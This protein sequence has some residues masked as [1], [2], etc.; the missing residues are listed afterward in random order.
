MYL[1]LMPTDNLPALEIEQADKLYHL[2]AYVFLSLTWFSYFI[3]FKNKQ[4]NL[5]FNIIAAALI[6]FGIVVEVLQSTLTDYRTFDWWDILSNSAGTL[7]V[8]F[9][10]KLN[11]TKLVKLRHQL[12]V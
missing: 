9:I 1:S 6:V 5:S 2:I 7:I 4:Q 10:F 11:K 8:Y 3:V 12:N